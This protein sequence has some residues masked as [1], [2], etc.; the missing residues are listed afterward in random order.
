MR[1]S[2]GLHD[3]LADLLEYPR[4][5]HG[6][7]TRALADRVSAELPEAAHD[8]AALVRLAEA[9]DLGACEEIYV[10]TFDGNAERALEVGWQVFGEQYAR[11][12]FLVRLREWMRECGVAETSE[13]P[14]HLT[15]VLRLIGRLPDE[16]ARLL[17][18][19]AVE[20]SLARVRKGLEDDSP[21]GGVLAA[22]AKAVAAHG[23]E[24]SPALAAA[25]SAKGAAR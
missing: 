12:A 17:V 7:R 14:D 10:R 5:G 9:G 6:A 22:V 1:P 24:S 3:A 18:G 21:Y 11:G 19:A 16:T 25:G 4:E 13:L 2:A 20:P 15:H 8:L 23:E